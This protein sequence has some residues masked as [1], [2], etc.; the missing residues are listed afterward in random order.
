MIES[1]APSGRFGK[2]DYWVTPA[3][4]FL[5][6]II[7]TAMLFA[8][9]G[10]GA[11]TNQPPKYVISGDYNY[12]PYEYLD[13][14][15]QPA[16][17]NVELSKAIG[18]ILGI[19]FD[20]RL[21]KWSL[22]RQGLEKGDVDL[23]QGMA[24]SAERART[25]HFSIPHTQ[26]WRS[27]FV[28]NASK[29]KS[30]DDI[31]NATL[32][33]QQ[34]DVSQ[35]YLSVIGF[36]GQIEECPTQTDA[37]RLLNRGLYDATIVNH[38]HGM[39]LMKKNSFTNIS[40]L[41]DKIQTRDYCY[42]SMDEELIKKIN[43]A[44][45]EMGRTGQ[46]KRLQD[47]WFSSYRPRLVA[48]SFFDGQHLKWTLPILAIL[49]SML[50]YAIV[51]SRKMKKKNQELLV[52][53]SLC[54]AQEEELKRER[55]LFRFGP[56]VVYKLQIEPLQ[57]L[58]VSSN[59]SQFGYSEDEVKTFQTGLMSI[60]HPDD[61]P[62]LYSSL[63]NQ[64]KEAP[65]PTE[66]RYRILTKSGDYV[67][68][69]DYSL[70]QI[71]DNGHIISYGYLIDI[72]LSKELEEN[73]IDEKLKAEEGSLAKSQFL[74]GVSHEI[75]N[76]LN[77]IL[78]LINLLRDMKMSTELR[79]I[80]DL[81]DASGHSLQRLI[82][83]ILDLSR[84]ESGQ[85]QKMTSAFNPNYLLEDLV[86]TFAR[87]K[88]RPS[89]DIRLNITDELPE[90]L[91]GDH[92]RT[93][94]IITNLMHNAIKF[95]SEGWV[96]LNA[97]IYSKTED[98]IRILFSVQDTGVGIAPEH[99]E[100]IFD[101]Y[102]QDNASKG[103]GSGT[104]LGL[105][106]VK[107]L[108]GLLGGVIWMESEVGKGSSFYIILPYSLVSEPENNV[109]EP[110][111]EAKPDTLP[112]MRVLIV[113]SDPVSRRLLN[114]QL[115]AWGLETDLADSG[116]AA[117]EKAARQHYDLLLIDMQLPDTD[118]AAAAK[119][120]R[121]S[122]TSAAVIP[123]IFIMSSSD[124]KEDKAMCLEAGVNEFITKPIIFRDLHKMLE[125]LSDESQGENHA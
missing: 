89:V 5:P 124:R 20:I 1:P 38:V 93:R 121:A 35:E 111:E 76:P 33:M 14:N 98:S 86:N 47:K 94:Q 3:R 62:E 122:Q 45:I 105:A 70:Y 24:L 2:A 118:G 49:L 15:Q 123:P 101:L 58:Y 117:I 107:R 112:P 31:I 34:G 16:G 22:A 32:I 80:Y 56:V 19:E 74:A 119:A 36:K 7:A 51:L 41:S 87:Q 9:S 48:G 44:L 79:E 109:P 81:I 37:L 4:W 46:L 113:E 97:S 12:P 55:D 52:K 83:D 59:V 10:L 78:G 8:F 26:T 17:Y 115:K 90:I 63:A 68:V 99:H 13:E 39:Y 69:Y 28:A 50:A 103:K 110:L 60:V 42:A 25:M 64:N 108:I 18:K 72:S 73:L 30:L 75:R 53:V 54:R 92:V 6:V 77:G 84:I 102:Y 120:I 21:T 27:V 91:M 61:L 116:N 106:I 96:Q 43:L 29:I 23:L 82:N 71:N 40:V 85:L 11:Q 57:M 104:G 67:W 95:T 125:K 66:N 88:E 65:Q 114:N 100:H